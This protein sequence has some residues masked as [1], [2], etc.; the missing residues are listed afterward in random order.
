VVVLVDA[1]GEEAEQILARTR[2][3]GHA[4]LVAAGTS[5]E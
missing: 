2:A 5:D 3:R 1:L 4:A